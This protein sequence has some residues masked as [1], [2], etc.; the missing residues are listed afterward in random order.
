MRSSVTPFAPGVWVGSSL[1]LFAGQPGANSRFYSRKKGSRFPSR[2]G[3]MH[4]PFASWL[5]RI[6]STDQWRIRNSY[7]SLMLPCSMMVL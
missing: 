7:S 1:F 2:Q 3:N 6:I 4:R 5:G